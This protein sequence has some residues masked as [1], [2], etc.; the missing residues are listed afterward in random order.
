MK[1]KQQC[2]EIEKQTENKESYFDK[3]D[4]FQDVPEE[5]REKFIKPTMF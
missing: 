5:T 1:T 2:D 4:N 3:Y